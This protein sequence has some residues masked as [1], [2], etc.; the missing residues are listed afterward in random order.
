MHDDTSLFQY[1]P[2][3]GY[4]PI[5]AFAVD[6]WRAT[7]MPAARRQLRYLDE[8]L[9]LRCTFDLLVAGLFP[10]TAAAK[11]LTETCAAFHAARH[12]V[13]WVDPRDA[14]TTAV[15]VG[16]GGTPRTAAMFA[17]RSRWMCHSIDPLLTVR[18]YG[19]RRL[20]I[21]PKRA[22]E[23]TLDIEGDVVLVAMHS[24]ASFEAAL[25]TVPRAKRVAY[26]CVPCCVPAALAPWAPDELYVDDGILSPDRRVYIWNDVRNPPFKG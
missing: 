25:A 17:L 4:R 7:G 2:R 15:V 11:E 6:A 13:K 10:S 5:R 20:E 14:R 16:D 3:E 9:S 1:N 18:D 24:H 8:V 26:V 23:V 21:H 22:E 12:H 19:I